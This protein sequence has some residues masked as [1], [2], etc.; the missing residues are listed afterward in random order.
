MGH[1]DNGDPRPNSKREKDDEHRAKRTLPGTTEESVKGVGGVVYT[2]G[3]YLRTMA[4]DV[5]KKGAVAVLS[6]MVPTNSWSN[7]AMRPATSFPFAEYA[8]TVAKEKNIP[9]LDHTKYTIKMY[10]A[11]GEKASA[12]YFWSPQ[13]T[14]H[15]NAAGAR[16][17]P[18]LLFFNKRYG[19]MSLL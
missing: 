2:F 8:K 19:L 13:D 18:L 12:G 1:N 4:S 7:G 10:N 14:T 3:H 5:E 11:K 15:T 17:K 9:Y 6:G 16:G